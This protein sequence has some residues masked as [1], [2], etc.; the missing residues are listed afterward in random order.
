ME[1]GSLVTCTSFRGSNLSPS[2]VEYGEWQVF[3]HVPWPCRG[4]RVPWFQSFQYTGSH[5][6][7]GH[8]CQTL[9]RGN[10]YRAMH[11]HC[12]L[13]REGRGREGRGGGREGG[14]KKVSGEYSLCCWHT[15]GHSAEVICVNFSTT[16]DQILTGSF[17]NTVNIWDT[18]TGE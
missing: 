17:D 12:E 16:G 15:Q 14:R 18:A 13:G 4:D 6:Q 3:P 9:E 7:Y 11:T 8:H 5:R 1:D 2:A 10:W